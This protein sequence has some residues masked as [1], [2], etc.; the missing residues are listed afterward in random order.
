MSQEHIK[1]SLRDIDS[2]I[3]KGERRLIE[4]DK[5]MERLKLSGGDLVIAHDLRLN[6]ETGLRLFRAVRMRLLAELE[7]TCRPRGNLRWPYLAA[8]L[9]GETSGNPTVFAQVGDPV[10]ITRCAQPG[11]EWLHEPC[12]PRCGNHRV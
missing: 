9:M 5:L 2:H 1:S 3:G 12:A 8:A 10:A 4:H 11:R 7:Q 6:I